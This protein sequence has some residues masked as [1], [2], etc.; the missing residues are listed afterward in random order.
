VNK[1]SANDQEEENGVISNGTYAAINIDPPA[2]TEI[3]QAILAMKNNKA[4]GLDDI[5]SKLLKTDV[6]Q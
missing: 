2:K 5:P 4:A 6:D 3:K 1:Q